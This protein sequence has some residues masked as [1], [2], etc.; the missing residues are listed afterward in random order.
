MTDFE[1]SETADGY[2]RDL[3]RIRRVEGSPRPRWC[4]EVSNAGVPAV[5]RRSLT[6]S[7]HPTLRE[8]K[9][10]ARCDEGERIRR[11][12]LAGHV[13]LGMAASLA[14][15][16]VSSTALALSVT[17]FAA[18]IALFYL[19]LGSFADA[20]E[21][22]LGNGWEWAGNERVSLRSRLADRWLLSLVEGSRRRWLTAAH[23]EPAPSVRTLSPTESGS[24]ST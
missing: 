7:V 19:A 9:Y 22:W 24:A 15:V 1:W 2:Q 21:V 17:G 18:A 8:A 14:Y 3:Y 12:R 11:A 20:V 4:L 16:A 6:T 13:V 10:R 5:A 23:A